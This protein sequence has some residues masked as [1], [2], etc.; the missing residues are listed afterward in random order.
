MECDYELSKER[1]IK[2]VILQIF[3][4]RILEREN[5]SSNLLI[6]ILNGM[7]TKDIHALLSLKNSFPAQLLSTSFAPLYIHV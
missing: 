4:H 3:Y 5:T 2:H 6:T 1:I 7:P